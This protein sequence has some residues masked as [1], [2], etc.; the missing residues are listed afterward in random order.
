MQAIISVLLKDRIQARLLLLAG[1]F[2]GLYS[3]ALT[4]SPIVR[5]RSFDEA[6]RWQHWLGFL[7]WLCI[8][9]V[10]YYQVRHQLPKSDPY[11]LPLVALLSGWGLL[12]I[13]RLYPDFGLRQT[14]WMIVSIVVFILGV[15]FA[16]LLSFLRRYK[17]LWLTTGL[18]LTALTLVLGT[19]PM[20]GSSPRLWLGCCGVYFQP[21]EPLKL[22]LIIYLAAY[23]ADRQLVVSVLPPGESDS[24]RAIRSQRDIRLGLSGPAPAAD[25]S[26]LVDDWGD[27]AP[28]AGS[29]RLGNRH[30]FYFLIFHNYLSGYWAGAYLVSQFTGDRA[31]GGCRVCSVRSSEL[32]GGLPG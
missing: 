4:L 18:L 15:R 17:Y 22:L 7:V 1:L 24:G 23:F 32:A 31:G 13:W 10:A 5:F 11:L 2:L 27:I 26:N 25:C 29:A 12:T 30:H 9:A 21:S 20:T 3:L 28:V 6:Y 8:F 14:I 19:N 16:G